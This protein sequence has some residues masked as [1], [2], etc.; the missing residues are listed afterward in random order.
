MEEVRGLQLFL[1]VLGGNGSKNSLHLLKAVGA[2][3]SYIKGLNTAGPLYLWLV[4]SADAKP[5]IR[6]AHCMRKVF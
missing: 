6:R 2:Q 4:A 3:I 1:C 5:W